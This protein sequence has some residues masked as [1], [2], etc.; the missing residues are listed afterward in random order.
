[1][2]VSGPQVS[3]E[4]FS[5]G[6]MY[7]PEWMAWLCGICGGLL[8]VIGTPVMVFLGLRWLMRKCFMRL[9]VRP[10]AHGRAEPT[11]RYFFRWKKR[12]PDDW[13]WF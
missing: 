12:L 13:R 1:M 10:F 6:D 3:P 7:P 9:A 11:Q 5:T 8:L 4:V 2:N